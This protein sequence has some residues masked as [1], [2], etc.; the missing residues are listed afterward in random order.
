VS[1]LTALDKESRIA[2]GKG[3]KQ[4]IEEAET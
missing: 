3:I 1:G 4:L 2:F